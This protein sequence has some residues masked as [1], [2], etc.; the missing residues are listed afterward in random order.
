MHQNNKSTWFS[1]NTSLELYLN[2]WIL[3]ELLLKLFQSKEQQKKEIKTQMQILAE[4]CQNRTTGKGE[5][6]RGPSVAQIK[7]WSTNE[8]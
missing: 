2:D 3:L 5:F 4:I 6:F 7:K 8:S 1:F